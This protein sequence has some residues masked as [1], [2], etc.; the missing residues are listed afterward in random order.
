MPAGG[1]AIVTRLVCVHGGY[2]VEASEGLCLAAFRGPHQA[3]AWALHCK[4]VGRSAQQPAGGWEA[5]ER[6]GV[7]P[8][9]RGG[10]GRPNRGLLL[11]SIGL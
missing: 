1:Q 8:V 11:I 9:A 5:W 6:A 4:Q 7:P 2:V 10:R 3:V